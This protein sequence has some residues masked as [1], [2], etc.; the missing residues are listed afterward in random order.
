MRVRRFL[1]LLSVAIACLTTAFA[2]RMFPVELSEPMSWLWVPLFG[3]TVFVN[4]FGLAAIMLMVPW[5]IITH[6]W[7]NTETLQ[8]LDDAAGVG[9]DVVATATPP[10][11]S[12]RV[13]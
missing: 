4:S 3:G 5:E 9:L 7:P 12:D 13:A 10:L 11:S 2:L 1:T 8:V 6:H